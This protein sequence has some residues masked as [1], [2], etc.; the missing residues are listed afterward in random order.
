VADRNCQITWSIMRRFFTPST[1]VPVVIIAAVA[2][3]VAIAD[4]RDVRQSRVASSRARL[5]AVAAPAPA[6]RISAHGS[7][8]CARASQRVPKTSVWP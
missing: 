4:W 2:A 3:M 7:S 6:A 8:T 1:I 5:P